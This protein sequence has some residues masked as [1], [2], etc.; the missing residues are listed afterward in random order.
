MATVGILGISGLFEAADYLTG[1]QYQLND[2]RPIF[3][4]GLTFVG[5]WLSAVAARAGWSAGDRESANRGWEKIKG[6]FTRGDN[7]ETK[8]K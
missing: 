2:A 3:I 6:L 7:K 4:G 5:L 1:G 8:Q